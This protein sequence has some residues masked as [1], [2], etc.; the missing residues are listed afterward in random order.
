AALSD[1]VIS[2]PS[3]FSVI[4]RLASATGVHPCWVTQ[5]FRCR[6]SGKRGV[7]RLYCRCMERSWL[8]WRRVYLC[9]LNSSPSIY[10]HV[11]THWLCESFSGTFTLACY[12][13]AR[14]SLYSF[15]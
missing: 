2:L 15:D 14:L 9:R 5:I 13:H 4:V 8:F 12:R 10:L 7:W 1:A 3:L 11:G 6:G